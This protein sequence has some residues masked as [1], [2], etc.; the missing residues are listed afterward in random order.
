MRRFFFV[1]LSLLLLGAFPIAAQEVPTDIPGELVYIPFPVSI[2]LNG[3]L[4]DWNSIPF[5][6]VT[7]GP[8]TSSDPAENGSVHFALAADAQNLYIAAT[9]PDATII[10]GLHEQEFWNEDSMEFYL[11]LSGQRFAPAYQD[12]IFQ[13]NINPGD[14]GNT[15]PGAI[16]LTGV[17]SAKANVQAYVFK[18]QD[19]WGFEAQYPF[20]GFEPQHGLEI[21]FQFQANG[22]SELD[23]N[24]KLIWSNAD[25]SDLSW[26]NPSLFGSAIF[27]ELGQTDLPL[28]AERPANRAEP[29]PAP[30]E[31]RLSLNQLGYLPESPKY[32]MLAGTE[33]ASALWD[34]KDATSGEILLSGQTQPA[35]FDEASGDAVQ[36]ADFSAWTQPGTYTLSMGGL[37]SAPFEITNDLYTRLSVDALRYFYLNRSGIALEPDF[38]GLWSRPAGHLSDN[39]LTCYSGTD[40]AGK[41]WDGCDYFLDA[42]KGWYDAGDYGK[43]VV[44]GGIAVW[45]LLNAYE[46]HPAIFTD[47]TNIPESG[48]AIPD[49]LD[50]A[51]WELEFL[52]GMQVPADQALGGM[53]HHKAH[54]LVWGGL[55]LLPETEVDNTDPKKGRLLMPPSTAATFN[56]AAVAAQCARIYADFD[57]DFSARCLNAAESAWLAAENNPVMLAGNTPGEGGGNYDDQNVDDERFWAAAELYISTG[58]ELYLAAL[59]ASPY[60][61]M[62]LLNQDT[63]L[64][65]WGQTNALGSLS[66]LTVPNGLPEERI[67]RLQEQVVAAADKFLAVMNQEGY[68]IS[69]EDYAFVWG[70]NSSI[71]NNAIAFAYAYEITGDP[72]YWNAITESMDWLLGRNALAVS[73]ISGYGQ[74]SM[75][76][77]HHRFWS[78]MPD[79]GFPA[80]PPG[81]I[82]GG[83]NAYPSDDAASQANLNDLPPAKRYID[84]IGSF[85]TNEVAINWNAPLVWVTSFIQGITHTP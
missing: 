75:Q 79:A 52:L 83:V 15:D 26:S 65:W 59:N 61:D 25:I 68:R 55:P 7:Q 1:I 56:L 5:I 47:A 4:D 6:T 50:E 84:D 28:P 27:Y 81:A 58:N 34:L 85:S 77:P 46:D 66:L 17:N 11:N 14:I 78:N 19:G 9:M 71:L 73:F 37:E 33:Q 54:E 8:Y 60:L 12:G 67:T 35:V 18:T 63:S 29:T 41:T 21:G 10:T 44:N 43:Y 80:P 38:A 42:S 32:A 40:A 64:M 51:R 48:N 76:H 30:P 69:L 82:A 57:P 16:T 31:Q 20:N 53:V 2:T 39:H 70:S 45:S 24:V 49:I 22:A 23:R 13:I 3:N 36:V 62:L 74:V 72:V